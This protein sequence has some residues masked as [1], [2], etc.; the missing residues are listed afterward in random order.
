MTQTVASMSSS[1]RHADFEKIHSAF[2]SHYRK[3]LKLGESRYSDWVKSSGLDETQSYYLQGAAWANKFRQSFEWANFLFQFVKEDK[4]T[5]DYKVE[6]LF[7]VES[8]NKDSSPFTRD[9]VFA[10]CSFLNG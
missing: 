2:L 4:E 6:A 9:E 7:P 5:L 10:G 3:D 8:V 1:I